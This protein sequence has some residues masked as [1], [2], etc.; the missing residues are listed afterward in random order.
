[1]IKKIRRFFKE[2]LV[3]DVNGTFRETWG[4]IFSKD[5]EKKARNPNSAKYNLLALQTEQKRKQDET[6]QT[7]PHKKRSSTTK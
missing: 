5:K 3:I 4:D 1:M 2:G 7:L 6:P